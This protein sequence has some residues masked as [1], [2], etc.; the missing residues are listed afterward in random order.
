MSGWGSKIEWS[1]MWTFVGVV[2]LFSSAIGVTLIAPKYID[3][4]WQ[5]A[6]SVYQV[7]MYEVSDPNVYFS[8]ANPG[9]WGLQY[10]YHLK[11]G[12]TLMAYRES[13]LVRLIAS[14]SLE[15]YVTR[16]GDPE[17]KLTTR[18]LL[19]RRPS[20]QEQAQRV[21]NRLQQKW[22]MEHS[23]QEMPYF[24]IWE[25]YDPDK[26]EAF[27]VN[28]TEGISERW[29]ESGFKIIGQMPPY[30]TAKG[31]IY[32][33]NPE[34]YRVA[35]ANYLGTRYWLYDQNGEPIQDLHELKAGKLKFL[36][37]R[38][39]I[40]MGEDIYRVEG[41]WYCHTD[42]TRTLVQDTVLNGSAD[43]PAP[44]SSAN[45][46]IFQ[47][48]TFP[49]T[50]RI[51]PDLSRVG[52]K[53]PNRDWHMSHFWSPKS[54]S[55]GSIMPSFK[56]FFDNDPTGT[57]PSPFGIPNYRFEAVF[58]YLM[59]KGTRITPPNEAWWLGRDPIQTI[60]IIEGRRG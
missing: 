48:V 23:N 58:Q 60:D 8:T 27:A 10:V 31:A 32:V 7:Q 3:P 44:P 15:P 53:R 30:F 22:K 41:C 1:A 16:F 42:Q 25:V 50:R 2:V 20:D 33:N 26:N 9:R 36:S 40:R 49:G 57:A 37:R 39:L 17:I 6:S 56:H 35:E 51:G 18:L 29:V 5:Q 13:E 21:Q 38:E 11:E 12:F 4:S 47:R 14:P 59:T 19:L 45:E 55:A 34:E 24:D 52:I 46:Y 43:F 28:E 54:E